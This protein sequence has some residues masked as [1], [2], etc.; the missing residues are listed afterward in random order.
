MRM[1]V[2]VFVRARHT[3]DQQLLELIRL[4]NSEG[5]EEEEEREQYESLPLSPDTRGHRPAGKLWTLD[6]LCGRGSVRSL[7]PAGS[8]RSLLHRSRKR[9]TM[10]PLPSGKNI[11]LRCIFVPAIVTETRGC[12]SEVKLGMCL[13]SV[14]LPALC[15]R[16]VHH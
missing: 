11:P 1:C 8:Q 12:V 15:E 6:V 9:G 4:T 2:W 5:G 7:A 3:Q 14:E 13:W 10:R 16:C